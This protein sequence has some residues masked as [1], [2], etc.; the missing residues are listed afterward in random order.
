MFLA[1]DIGNTNIVCG[2]YNN[3][4]WIHN[5]R[6]PSNMSFWNEFSKIKKFDILEVGISSVV[7]KLTPI[8]YESTKNLF[9]IDP[10]IITYKNANI[11]LEVEEPSQVGV[12]RICNVASAKNIV[13]TPAI[14]GDIGSA[15]NFDVI[16]SKGV[17]VGGVIA[18]G[19]ETAAQNL[20]Q[21]AALLKRITFSMPSKP[22]GK[23]TKSNL[24]SGIMFGAIDSV[25]GMFKR[26]NNETGWLKTHHI[27]TGGFGKVISPYLETK[28]T[29]LSN[30]TLDGIRLIYESQ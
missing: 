4:K 1:I 28:H 2:I 6:L 18:P 30:L 14:I 15:T 24:Q 20:F 25:D 16:N 21:K 9:N 22:I 3:S 5:F 19:I 10:F 13:G 8:L 26:I 7:P 29:L 27:I 12:D 23:N 17:F 11:E